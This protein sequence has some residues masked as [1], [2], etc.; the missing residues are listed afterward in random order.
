MFVDLPL[1]ELRAYRP[2]VLEPA[3]FDAF[4]AREAAAARA[5]DAEP[6][7]AEMATPIRHAVVFDVTFSGYN[8]EPIRSWLLVPREGP[9]DAAFVVEYVGYNGGRGDSL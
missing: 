3:D 6:E 8:G 2:D 1:A 5:R 7:F 4:W 9:P